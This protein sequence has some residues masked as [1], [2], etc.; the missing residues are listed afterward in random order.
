MCNIFSSFLVSSSLYLF[1]MSI[2]CGFKKASNCHQLSK[3]TFSFQNCAF[4]QVIIT[5]F[6]FH[7]VRC[8]RRFKC[9]NQQDSFCDYQICDSVQDCPDGL[10]EKGC[11]TP[12]PSPTS[13]TRKTTTTTIT[14]K[15]PNPIIRCQYYCK[16]GQCLTSEML[17]GKNNVVC[18]GIKNCNDG[19]DESNCLRCCDGTQIDMAKKCDGKFDCPDGS[20]EM[21]CQKLG[22][23]KRAF[24]AH[25]LVF[26]RTLL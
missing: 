11:S 4:L 3:G 1:G 9:G 22:N 8:Q 23:E 26:F 18:D 6:T 24:E 20:D 5:Q 7:I 19:S 12:S 15:P 2:F 25:I 14:S 13:S 21:Y 17:G 16:N 10:D